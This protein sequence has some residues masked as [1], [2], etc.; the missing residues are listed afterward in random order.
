MLMAVTCQLVMESFR[1][2]FFV[3]EVEVLEL[4]VMNCHIL[5]IVHLCHCS[6]D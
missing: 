1:K 6:K 5:Y 2:L 4:A 3:M